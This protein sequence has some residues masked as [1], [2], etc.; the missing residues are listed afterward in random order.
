MR[1][2]NEK[3]AGVVTTPSLA[4]S[5]AASLMLGPPEVV[6][7]QRIAEVYGVKP[8]HLASTHITPTHSTGP[9]RARHRAVSSGGIDAPLSTARQ[10]RAVGG[11]G[12]VMRAA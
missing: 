7:I 4:A 1:A 5:G 9:T 11:A 2:E 3:A 10:G 6:R 8:S 12:E